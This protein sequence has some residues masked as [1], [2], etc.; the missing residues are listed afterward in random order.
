M[1]TPKTP[2]TFRKTLLSLAVVTMSGQ[3]L[4]D[5]PTDSDYATEKTHKFVA[6][7]SAEMFSTVNEILC[8]LAQSRYD[9][10]VNKGPYR[11]LIDHGLCS[12]DSD[13][14]S[15][16][17]D[18]S[19]NQSSGTNAP[20]YGQWTVSASRT[21]NNSPQI[22]KFWVN[23]KAEG[24]QDG[25]KQIQA[26]LTITEGK[27]DGNPLGLFTLNFEGYPKDSNGNVL[28]QPVFAGFMD[29]EP[30]NGQPVLRFLMRQSRP[31]QNGNLQTMQ[32][33]AVL[34]KT[35]SSGAGHTETSDGLSSMA[36]AIAFNDSNF[37]RAPVA[38]GSVDVG[39]K[40]CYN[41]NSF[42]ES[43]WRYGLYHPST[44]ARIQR[45]SG[46]PVKFSDAGKDYF[47][48]VGYYGVWF[49]QDV[50]LDNGDTV[51]KQD[52]DSNTST[53]YTVMKAGGKLFKMTR[54]ELQLDEV[55]GIPLN[56]GQCDMNGCTQSQIVWNKTAAAF[57]KIKVMQESDGQHLWQD[58]NPPVTLTSSD[59]GNMFDLNAYSESLGGSVR[60]PL[61]NETQQYQAPSGST[62]VNLTVQTPVYP[63]ATG[64]PS[65]LRCYDQCPD[66]AHL[67]TTP[68]HQNGTESNYSFATS[69]MLL[70]ENGTAVV[71]TTASDTFR[72]G[73][74][75]GP[76]FD[77]TPENLAQLAC[78]WDANQTCGWLAWQKLPEFYVWETGTQPWNQL[79]LLKDANNNFLTFQPPLQLNYT[80]DAASSSVT[81]G[82]TPP[83]TG[84]KFFLQYE[85]FGNL[86]GIPG[87]CVDPETN[88]KAQCGPGVRW[89]PQ[90][91][92]RDSLP[93]P[94]GALL[95]D[96]NAPTTHYLVKG[97]DKE[98][99]MQKVAT[100]QCDALT[101]S[102]ASNMPTQGSLVAPQIGNEPIV[103]QAPAVIGGVVQ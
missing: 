4:A 51:Y 40:A 18:A 53:P 22:V 100:S 98:Q 16:A 38:S 17:A 88:Q 64:L 7:R 93:T 84:A 90:F 15:A 34:Q 80:F 46:F 49:P 60:V 65:D 5:V 35:G 68:F 21:D 26:K 96:A 47:G 50:T 45:Q 56:W 10:M 101:L 83:P 41:R 85:G 39:Q 6:E 29:V 58:V 102:T 23:E 20:E 32:E 24:P 37:L 74:R 72:Y 30:S 71:M 91:S 75:S 79:T 42:D 11:A 13:D 76:L 28:S 92:L 2:F 8:M 67:D 1:N 55:A 87:D 66:A 44:G 103:D 59:F 31:D 33:R 19:Q 36:F 54:K 14:P 27:S 61:K 70:K 52:F 99:R 62:P 81:D 25:D 94:P 48:W 57:Q 43:V 69:D 77:P 73:L 86:H 78:P 63:T 12:S 82:V 9:E 89:V 97:L 3:A 95:D